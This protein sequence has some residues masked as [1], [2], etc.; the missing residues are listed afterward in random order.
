MKVDPET[1]RVS[2]Y[3]PLLKDPWLMSDNRNQA[4]AMAVGLEKRLQKRTGEVDA[5]NEALRDFLDRGTLCEVSEEE[6][7][8]W[9]GPQKYQ[10]SPAPVYV[11]K[12]VA[13]H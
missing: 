11:I 3:Y 9:E 4:L 2:F 7:A 13:Q 10:G 5:Y 8:S 1:K 12:A 6:M